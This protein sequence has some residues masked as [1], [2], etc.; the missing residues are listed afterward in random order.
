MYPVRS[1]VCVMAM[2]EKVAAFVQM[3][4]KNERSIKL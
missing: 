2:R 4:K 3:E 1:P